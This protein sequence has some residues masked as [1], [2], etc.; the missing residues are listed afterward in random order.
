MMNDLTVYAMGHYEGLAIDEHVHVGDNLAKMYD[1]N[2][3][4]KNIAE[5]LEM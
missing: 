5:I 2:H 1:G 3:L 4:K